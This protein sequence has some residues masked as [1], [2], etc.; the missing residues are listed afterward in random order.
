MAKNFEPRQVEPKA[1][2]R[3][4]KDSGTLLSRLGPAWVLGWG[5]GLPLLVW[6]VDRSTSDMG[7]LV[8]LIVMFSMQLIGVL[9]QPFLQ[10]ALDQANA[11]GRPGPG[12]ALST[13]CMEMMSQRRWFGRRVLGQ[14]GAITALLVVSLSFMLL[15]QSMA[16][17]DETE[18][19]LAHPLNRPAGL[20]V[21]LVCVPMLLRSHGVFDFSYWLQARH[22]ADDQ[23]NR[24][25]QEK[26]KTM[27][28]P[29]LIGGVLVFVAA[30]MIATAHPLLCLMGL[31]LIQMFMAA[32]TRCAYHDIFEGGTGIKQTVEAKEAGMVP[33]LQA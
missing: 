30:V 10:H 19:V 24:M 33:V 28:A 9:C 12:W 20:L 1:L 22:G 23:T 16:S 7:G 18:A 15:I 5:L 17:P 6:L 32:F 13:T 2:T 11:G 31:P 21:W 8:L 25:L 3:W 27:N 4:A 14:V 26:S 29:T